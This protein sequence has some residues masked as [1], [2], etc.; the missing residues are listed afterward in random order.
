MSQYQPRSAM[1][2]SP[3]LSQ[4]FRALWVMMI[5]FVLIVVDS[6]VVSVANP[7]LKQ[8]FDVEYHSVIWVTTAYLVAFSA[9]LMVGGRLGDRYG[10]KHVYMLGLALFTAASVWCGL[11]TSVGVLIAA[12]VAQGLGAALLT[13]QVMS[14]ITRTFPPQRHGVGMSVW[15]ATTGVGL[16]AGPII[17]GLL[18][19]GLGW[20]W[21]FFINVPI[22]VAGIAL[23]ARFLPALP[24]RPL[25]IDVVGALLSGAGI[26]LVVL[27]LQEGQHQ[28]WSMG[29]W[30]S[31]GGGVAFIAAFC[32]W[33]A[34]QQAEP[35]VPVA[36]M[37]NRNFVL[38]NAG[39]ALV[40]FAFVAFG[41]PLMIYL[42]EVSGLS[43]FHAAL[44]TAP[45]AVA[46]GAL[47]PFVGK[48]VDRAHPRPVVVFGF[49]LL[50]FALAW[51]VI[52]MA[53]GSAAWRLALPLTLVGVAGAFTWEPLSAIA[54]RGLPLD[55]AGAGSALCNT[56]RH[57]GAALS[58]A[59]V[60]AMM[61]FLLGDEHTEHGGVNE[62]AAAHATEGT[63]ADAMSQSILLAVLAAGLGALTGMF[64]N[65]KI[66]ADGGVPA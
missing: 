45:M 63:F 12:R 37:A 48:I 17:G 13:P 14:T 30:A 34:R 11:S 42:Q 21:I 50:G 31:L 43:P 29:I 5:G 36:L 66:P 44:L 18:L 2:S 49:A 19:A 32:V 3:A 56:V 33:Q 10:T 47:A 40:S 28:G 53:Q 38:S 20:Q 25:H 62:T 64:L 58:S 27:G 26:C 24:A 57:M 59:S 41:V 51:L 6:T 39:I 61:A 15:G 60:A 23:A 46:T 9:F 52:E 35:L 4:S 1:P 65:G 16:L 55:V 54:T 7:V 22:G 8:T